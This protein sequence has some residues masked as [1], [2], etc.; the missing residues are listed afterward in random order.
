MSYSTSI[1][2]AVAKPEV[3]DL[4]VPPLDDD[5]LPTSVPPAHVLT[6]EDAQTWQVQSLYWTATKT[7]WDPGSLFTTRTDVLPQDLVKHRS[8]EIR[9]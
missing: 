5:G 7:N 8:R 4:T 9:V 1:D 6:D 3:F 2:G